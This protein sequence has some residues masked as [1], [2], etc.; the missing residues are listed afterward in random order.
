MNS[1]AANRAGQ[2]GMERQVAV[3]PEARARE[4]VYDQLK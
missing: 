4:A 3:V 2:A 1:D